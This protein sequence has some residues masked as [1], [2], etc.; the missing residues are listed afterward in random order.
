MCFEGFFPCGA[1]VATLLLGHL[2]SLLLNLLLR[3]QNLQ[4]HS[5]NKETAS[6]RSPPICQ[7]W[8][9]LDSKN[10]LRKHICTH[11]KK[12]NLKSLLSIVN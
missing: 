7:I 4:E 9:E 6:W 5:L 10:T 11:T 12:S 8:L 2:D 1:D 3:L